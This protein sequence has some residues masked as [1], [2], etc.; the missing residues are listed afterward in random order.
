MVPLP[1]CTV[2][3]ESL[4]SFQGITPILCEK[5]EGDTCDI[6][7]KKLIWCISLAIYNYVYGVRNVLD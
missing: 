2:L 3:S 6:F 4:R 1:L 7:I 5:C